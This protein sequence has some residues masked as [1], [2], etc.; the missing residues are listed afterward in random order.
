MAPVLPV[1]FALR[2]P[3]IPTA[4]YMASLMPAR[5]SALANAARIEMQLP[6]RTLFRGQAAQDLENVAPWLV[7]L[8][9]DHPFL[10]LWCKDWDTHSGILLCAPC[11]PAEV[12]R[13][14]R[15]V[16][17]AQDESGQEYFFRFYDPRVLAKYL[18]GCKAEERKEFFGPIQ[19]ILC[20][21]PE[22]PGAV[23]RWNREASE[24]SVLN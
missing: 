3:G 5:N 1:C 16:F 17:V 4:P 6:A 23:A 18:P 2:F 11:N 20:S 7:S 8:A 14:L 12:L 22:S 13:H 10:D 24:P 9:G 21:I 19:W 15:K